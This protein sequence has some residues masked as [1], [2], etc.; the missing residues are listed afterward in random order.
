MLQLVQSPALCSGLETCL[1]FTGTN[2][3][4]VATQPRNAVHS[5]QL[6]A[7]PLKA[8]G[9]DMLQLLTGT[10][11]LPTGCAKSVHECVSLRSTFPSTCKGKSSQGILLHHPYYLHSYSSFQLTRAVN[12]ER[13][14]NKKL[15]SPLALPAYYRYVCTPLLS[16]ACTHTETCLREQGPLQYNQEMPNLTLTK[17]HLS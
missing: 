17:L 1:Y 4:G 14:C 3:M 8:M 13:I 12:W 6:L 16:H 2:A 11:I 7:F 15:P 9:D 5:P 10:Q